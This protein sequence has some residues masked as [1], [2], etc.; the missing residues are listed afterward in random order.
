MVMRESN[1]QTQPSQTEDPGP[2]AP[3]HARTRAPHAHAARDL[4]HSMGTMPTAFMELTPAFLEALR[5]IAPKSRRPRLSILVSMSVAVAL[6]AG[7]IV[8]GYSKRVLAM[9]EGKG[10]TSAPVAPPPASEPPVSAPVVVAPVAAPPPAVVAPA[11][12]APAA[13]PSALAPAPAATHA[14]SATPARAPASSPKTSSTPR[15]PHRRA[16]R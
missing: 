14:A 3:E 10:H 9:A 8:T 13:A 11:I 16:P 7:G 4:L 6:F 1:R 5:K 2:M 15:K 12:V